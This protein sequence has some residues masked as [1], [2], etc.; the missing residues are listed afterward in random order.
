MSAPLH[1]IHHRIGARIRARRTDLGLTLPQLAEAAG[2]S[3][4]F[5]SDVETGKANISI[6]RLAGIAAALG[7]PL[8]ALVREPPRG[9]RAAIDALLD[10]CDE[11][12][13]RRIQALVEGAVG[14][15]RPAIVA[16]L[17]IRGAGKSTVGPLLAEALG[18]PF[19][20]LDA[21]IS[22][23]AGMPV[24][25]IFTLHGE[26]YYRRL[27]YECLQ[28]LVDAGEPCVV[29]LPGGIVGHD[30][31]RQLIDAHC[32]SVW[33]RAD[34]EDYWARVFAQ[35]DTRPMQGRDDAMAELRA[36]VARREPLYARSDLVQDTSRAAPDEVAR[37]IAAELEHR[38]LR[39]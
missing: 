39:P 34:P 4:R 7:T 36:L 13:L 23:R 22:A 32:A 15:R 18:I 12:Q 21:R 37:R 6:G 16:L 17:G 35:G 11:A 14:A 8:H 31:A 25:D 38:G 2:V 28:A 26:P 1:S 33:L 5:L 10:R 20:E 30:A 9:P 29:A 19:V 3:A 27:E 24:G